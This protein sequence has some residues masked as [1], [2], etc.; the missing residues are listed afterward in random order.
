[1][2]IQPF[3]SFLLSKKSAPGIIG[4]LAQAAASDPKFPRQGTPQQVSELLNR[5][6]AP[7]EFH[8]A[9]EEAEAEWRA[10]H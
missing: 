4:E 2:S 8:E 7:G 5:H 9:L 6:Q 3:G 10:S 1:M